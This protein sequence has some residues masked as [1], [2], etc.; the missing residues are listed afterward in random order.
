M[1]RSSSTPQDWRTVRRVNFPVCC[2]VTDQGSRASYLA[3]DHRRRLGRGDLRRGPARLDAL[4][5]LPGRALDEIEARVAEAERRPRASVA[6]VIKARWR[7]GQRWKSPPPG[8]HGALVG[9]PRRPHGACR[10]PLPR[11]ELEGAAPRRAGTPRCPHAGQLPVVGGRPVRLRRVRARPGLVR[12]LQA[13][14][15]AVPPSTSQSPEVCVVAR[16]PARRLTRE[17]STTQPPGSRRRRAR[18]PGAEMRP[19]TCSPPTRWSTW[20]A[21]GARR[22]GAD[23]PERSRAPVRERS[24]S[25]LLRRP[26][27]HGAATGDSA[28][29]GWVRAMCAIADLRPGAA[30]R[31]RRRPCAQAA[32]QRASRRTTSGSGHRRTTSAR[33]CGPPPASEACRRQLAAD[34]PEGA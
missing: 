13:R 22:D 11:R 26:H 16:R 24:L 17:Y 23:R 3:P 4:P 8:R 29:G 34:D 30:A 18:P 15:G 31:P 9:R 25:A 21:P 19:S 7:C 20:W 5:R 6:P 28:G 32:A 14:G 12:S 1:S 27:G 10:P 33:T 2:T